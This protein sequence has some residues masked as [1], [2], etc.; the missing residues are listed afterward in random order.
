[1][2][3]ICRSRRCH[4]K[5]MLSRNCNTT[6]VSGGPVQ[7]QMAQWMSV[8]VSGT[9]LYGSDLSVATEALPSERRIALT[10]VARKAGVNSLHFRT[11]SRSSDSGKWFLTSYTSVH[12]RQ[13][14]CATMNTHTSLADSASHPLRIMQYELGQI[15]DASALSFPVRH[16]KTSP[17]T[18]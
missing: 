10:A 5:R 13:T 7:R 3:Y 16:C 15:Q 18:V 4:G 8:V 17:Y 11:R 12:C 2:A 1:M 9:T 6:V 14:T